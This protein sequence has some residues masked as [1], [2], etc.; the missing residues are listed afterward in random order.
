MEATLPMLLA[1]AQAPR[2]AKGR[3]YTVF[4]VGGQA[5][6]RIKELL[7]VTDIGELLPLW[8]SPLCPAPNAYTLALQRWILCGCAVNVEPST[9][10]GLASSPALLAGVAPLYP[11][12]SRQPLQAPPVAAAGRQGKGGGLLTCTVRDARP[13]NPEQ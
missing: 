4:K 9:G 5:L 10:L 6:L 11:W 1:V 13:W 2:K 3:I 7:A 12:A 8:D